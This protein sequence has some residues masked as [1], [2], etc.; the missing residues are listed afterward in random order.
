MFRIS[1]TLIFLLSFSPM[2]AY[3]DGPFGTHSQNTGPQGF[4]LSTLTSIKEVKDHSVDDQLVCVRGR[5]TEWLKGDKYWFV[6]E[7]G[8]GIETELDDD[9]DWSHIRKDQLV[10]IF[11]EVDKDSFNVELQVIRAK[12]LN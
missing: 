4:E 6:D 7:A 11:A 5:F 3:A 9:Y 2:F 12:P 1:K 10:E 8:E